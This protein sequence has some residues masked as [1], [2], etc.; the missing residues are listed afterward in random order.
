MA[1]A[2]AADI[3]DRW[4]GSEA[5]D[6]NDRVL[7]VLI[8]DAEEVILSR[9]PK[10]QE[11]IDNGSLRLRRVQIVMGGMVQRAYQTRQ[12]GLVSYS[13]GVGPFSEGGSY[14]DTRRGLYL[15]ADEISKL[16]PSANQKGK[17]F[18]I[19]LDTRGGSSVKFWDTG[20]YGGYFYRADGYT[21]EG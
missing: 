14:G 19:N 17:A 18:S 3:I 8:E 13:N 11:R 15:T 7:S 20:Y 5:P 10:I 2:T 6:E 16:A 12:D 21:G 4:T 9:F 1:W